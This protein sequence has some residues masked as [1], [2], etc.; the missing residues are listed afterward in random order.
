MI[1]WYTVAD[2]LKIDIMN[3]LYNVILCLLFDLQHL[4]EAANVKGQ[5]KTSTRTKQNKY[6]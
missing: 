6:K 4:P 5:S 3:G 1:V 2:S